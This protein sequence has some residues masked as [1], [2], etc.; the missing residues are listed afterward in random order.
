MAAE[1]DEYTPASIAQWYIDGYGE[2][3]AKAKDAALAAAK[4]SRDYKAP[5]N[6]MITLW[7]K[8]APKYS[9]FTSTGGPDLSAAVGAGTGHCL[10]SSAQWLLAAKMAA[11]AVATGKFPNQGPITT[12][13]KKVGLSYD[14]KFRVPTFKSLS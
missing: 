14:K 8:T 11:G 6:K 2:Q 10:Y 4:Q 5:V 3:F 1:S 9:K 13:A 7:A 12:Q